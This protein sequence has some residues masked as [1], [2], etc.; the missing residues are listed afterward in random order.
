MNTEKMIAEVLRE[1]NKK[2]PLTDEEIAKKLNIL[3]E[4]VTEY[5]KKNNIANS[6]NRRLEYVKTD[7]LEILKKDKKISDR[8]LA[9][10][11]K[12]KGYK[13]ERY[14][15]SNIKKELISNMQED[16][17]INEIK[18]KKTED[19]KDF[20]EQKDF[21]KEVVGYN[22][23][24]RVQVEQ[25]KAAV[26]YPPHGLHVLILG[27]SGVGKSYLAD[28]MYEFAKSTSNFSE[29]A[30][31]IIFNCA[32]YAD[33]PQLLLSQLFGSVKG[34]YTGAT[35]NKMGIVEACD[36]GILF[37]DEIHRLP[38]EGQEI[39]FSILDKGIFR[40]LG[41]S[42]T[43]RKSN[44]M[45]I[46]ATT[47]NVESSLLL[48]F[49]R[50]IPMVIEIP[51]IKDRPFEE[52]FELI[53]KA[54]FEE[55]H[56]IKKDMLISKNV[57]S[58]LMKYE[59]QGN[60]GQLKSDIQVA[61]AISF[62]EHKLKEDKRL[63][64][65]ERYLPDYIKE[66]SRRINIDD[67]D[68]EKFI[69]EDIYISHKGEKRIEEDTRYNK[70]NTN[71]YKFIEKRQSELKFVGYS[72]E[73]ISKI[74]SQQV[75]LELIRG[76]KAINYNVVNTDELMN[77]VGVKSLETVKMMIKL[78]KKELTGLQSDI[79]YPLAVHLNST[80]ERIRNGK[81]IINPK[82]SIIK[83]RY[84]KEYNVA[85]KMCEIVRERLNIDVPEDE[86]GF[87]TMYL[88]NY[89]RYLKTEEG[90]VAVIVMTHGRVAS[91][92]AEVANK[93]L[94]V[95]HAVGLDMDFRDSP[96]IMLEKAIRLVKENDQGKGCII[97]VDMGS[98]VT[99]G[100]IITAKTGIETRVI[101]RV[102][103]LMV[104]EA[105]RKSA[106]TDQ[107]L[108]EI[109]HDLE[110]DSKGFGSSQYNIEN[111]NLSKVIVTL[112]IT[113]K[114]SALKIKEYVENKIDLKGKDIEIIPIGFMDEDINSSLSRISKNKNIEAIVGTI[115]PEFRNIPFISLEELMK[116]SGVKKLNNI[117]SNKEENKLSEIIDKNVVF[118]NENYKYKDEALDDMVRKLIDGGYV[119]EEFLLSVFKRE[120]LGDTYLKG[121]IAIP[122]GA[123]EFV[124]K[125]T[126]LITKLAKKI[127][128]SENYEVDLIFLIALKDDS[129]KYFEQLYKIIMEESV[130][131]KIKS[132]TSKE[133][134]LEILL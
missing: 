76:A 134:I 39:L 133:E 22:G 42:E 106:L 69:I 19:I 98:L 66:Q 100:D 126:I 49:R 65:D 20:H 54:F 83:T 86:I 80:Y 3:R 17:Y 121:G 116:G 132:S 59:C 96:D 38:S 123:S 10:A 14:A 115:N 25:A 21:F 52:R 90:K 129:K 110:S 31:Y 118:V 122:H 125:P 11:L 113:G 12:E 117:I 70:K 74:L 82:L 6:R 91:A 84:E 27:P 4:I 7:A 109:M 127:V 114:G 56:R 15:A 89:T 28:A 75:E 9:E 34:A 24:L 53:N 77:L 64:I 120:M 102:D 43:V 8:A 2:N 108:E 95:D 79:I 33:N 18:D 35:E 68:I 26:S 16:D 57:I 45:I 72:D 13:V 50:R 85:K 104:L 40:R 73:E 78:A 81:E 36:G 51:A 63:Y 101:G 112:C 105:V 61:C 46:A 92:M 58:E 119:K 93:F 29:D 103:T 88:K 32:D 99:F 23:S 67:S 30:K 131:N 1:E 55:S 124:T 37:L 62:L 44:V 47:E 41:E 97:L 60:I 128:W 5:R 94:G 87:I 107:S 111:S 48:T 130:L 71:I